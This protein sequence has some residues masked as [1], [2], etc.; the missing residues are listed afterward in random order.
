LKERDAKTKKAVVALFKLLYY[1]YASIC[2]YLMIKDSPAIPPILGGSGS[3][4]NHFKDWP[5][6]EKPPYYTLF[7]MSCSGYHFAALID[8]FRPE[9]RKHKSFIE[10]AMHHMITMYLL[11]LSYMANIQSGALVLFIHNVSD[12]GITQSRILLDTKYRSILP[13]SVY[14]SIG[15]WFY[16]RLFCFGI[17][18]YQV[19]FDMDYFFTNN[20]IPYLFTYLFCSLY[21]LHAFWLILMIKMVITYY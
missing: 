14:Y 6:T 18:I 4:Y 13:L 19:L 10:L 12:V 8:I 5:F 11:V 20:L 2:G 9:N 16:F 21:L 17:L 7:F 15:S 1:I 3:F